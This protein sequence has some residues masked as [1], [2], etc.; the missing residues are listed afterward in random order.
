[1]VVA[2]KSIE[3]TPEL[4]GSIY[5]VA[6]EVEALGVKAL[7][8]PLDVRDE[9]SIQDMVSTTVKQLGAP[10]VLVNNASALWW[11]PMEQTP[12]SRYDLI[13]SVCHALQ[14]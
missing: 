14:M 11:K 7:P 5:T 1:M 6:E 3:S 9:K 4:P 10:A 2:A 13:M 12:I 8:F